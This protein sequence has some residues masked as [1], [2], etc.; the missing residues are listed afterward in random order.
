[1]ILLNPYR[2]AAAAGP[3][4]TTWDPNW[5]YENTSFSNGNLTV[6]KWTATTNRAL[7]RSITGKAGTGTGKYYF[8]VHIDTVGGNRT[9][10]GLIANN[11]TQS[12][13]D[14]GSSANTI[15]YRKD[16]SLY[17]EGSYQTGQFATYTTNDVIGV[18][19]DMGAQTVTFYKN[20][21]QTGTTKTFAFDTNRTYHPC[22]Q[23]YYP[24]QATATE[25]GQFSTADL[26][27]ALP[28]GYSIWPAS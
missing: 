11:Y 16:G 24:G 6:T 27:Y 15:A 13:G 20:G 7:A 19:F 28:S 5:G 9:S 1:M 8:E 17:N 10:V 3:D 14:L 22:V 12:F 23:L 2:F 4:G 21:S 26:S 18:A 25:T